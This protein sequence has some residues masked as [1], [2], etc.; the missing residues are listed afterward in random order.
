GRPRVADHEHPPVVRHPY[1]VDVRAVRPD[2]PQSAESSVAGAAH[3]E[4][5]PAVTGGPGRAVSEEALHRDDRLR[6]AIAGDV[7]VGDAWAIRAVRVDLDPLP[8][9]HRTGMAAVAVGTL[10]RRERDRATGTV[11]AGRQGD[12]GA[13]PVHPGDGVVGWWWGG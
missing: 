11:L 8:A 4:K 2:P 5:V 13:G 9:G 3:H 10:E 12:R 1:L 6:L 7:A